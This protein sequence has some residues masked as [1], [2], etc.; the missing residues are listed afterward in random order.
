MPQL[1]PYSSQFILTRKW[2]FSPD[3]KSILHNKRN[4]KF[5]SKTSCL[6]VKDVGSKFNYASEI[7]QESDSSISSKVSNPRDKRDRLYEK[8]DAHTEVAKEVV[9]DAKNISK[10]LDQSMRKSL[11]NLLE[12][13]TDLEKEI[14]V[15]EQIVQDM[16]AEIVKKKRGTSLLSGSML[17]TNFWFKKLEALNGKAT[18]VNNHGS[19]TEQEKAE[20]DNIISASKAVGMDLAQLNYN[21]ENLKEKRD[22]LNTIINRLSKKSS[23][24]DDFA[25]VSTEMPDHTSGDD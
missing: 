10:D 23:L 19:G 5:F 25:D 13:N 3:V 6:N 9:E 24:L 18:V 2:Y 12:S 8:I 7:D 16:W 1:I 14:Q 20:L 17:T 21:A 11:P 22:K 15:K 4:T